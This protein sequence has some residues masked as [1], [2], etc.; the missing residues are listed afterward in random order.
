M[1]KNNKNF[2]PDVSVI[3]PM[4]NAADFIEECLQSLLNQT[5]KNIEVI[6]IDDCSTDNSIAIVENMR[7]DFGEHLILMKTSTNSGCP[8]LP[9]NLALNVARGKYI[10][11]LDSDDFIDKTALEDFYKVAEEFDADVVHSEK[12]LAYR[13]EENK[14]FPGIFQQGKFVEKPTLETFDIGKRV[15][16]FTQKKYLW[17]VWGKLFRKQFLLD[18]KIEFPDMTNFEDFVFVFCCLVSAKNYVRVPFISYHY[19]ISQDSLSKNRT[20]NSIRLTQ[21]LMTAVNVMDSFMKDKIFFEKNHQSRYLIIDFF[22][23]MFMEAIPENLFIYGGFEPSQV[24]AFLC[25]EVFSQSPSENIALTSY[26]FVVAGIYKLLLN[27][28]D[29]QI[30]QLQN[31]L[32]K[33]QN[34]MV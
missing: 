25:S 33:L 29:A 22:A 18:N 30:E 34:E 23:Q 26:L 17:N 15:E 1:A 16:D 12:F 6:V 32:A 7:S 14:D 13:Q 9:R 11:F 3:I 27:D 24:Y 31:Q 28:K 4:Y 5:L 2:T 21:N 10:Y 20:S 8:G 19:R